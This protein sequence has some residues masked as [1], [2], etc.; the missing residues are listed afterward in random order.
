[1]QRV[2]GMLLL[3]GYWC[4]A[5]FY[6]LVTVF[7]GRWMYWGQHTP[8]AHHYH[9]GFLRWVFNCQIHYEDPAMR[10]TIRALPRCIM[11]Y[12]HRSFA[13]FSI[14]LLSTAPE[15]CAVVSRWAVAWLFPLAFFYSLFIEKGIVLFHRGAK[16]RESMRR[17]LFSR[18]RRV[19]ERGR[20]LVVFPEGHRYQ[21]DGTLPLKRGAINWAY[22]QNYPCAVILQKG[23]EQV[24][25]EKT[26]QA[27][28]GMTVR[29]L[30]QG[31]YLPA[32]FATADA[33]YD[34]IAT[35]FSSGYA[36]LS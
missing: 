28:R 12:N 35:G 32:D 27:K 2:K 36:S 1:M 13:D 3:A 6:V 19:L 7:F 30:H 14:S 23:N 8:G 31:I 34:A 21:G 33:F 17:Q 9:K 16:D 26:L 25:N 11:L 29:C 22:A 20:F 5:Q 4:F 15:K 24:F 10:E 18:M